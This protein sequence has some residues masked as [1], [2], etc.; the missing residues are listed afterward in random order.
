MAWYFKPNTTKYWESNQCTRLLGRL[1]SC[2]GMLAI[3]L[4][5]YISYSSR[6]EAKK[7]VSRLRFLLK[8]SSF[9]AGALKWVSSPIFRNTL[10]KGLPSFMFT[11][12]WT[13]YMYCTWKENTLNIRSKQDTQGSQEFFPNFSCRQI[14]NDCTCMHNLK[15]VCCRLPNDVPAKFQPAI[16][17]FSAG[18]FRW[19]QQLATTLCSLNEFPL[20]STLFWPY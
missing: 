13:Q 7:V 4:G 10:N 1:P 14:L 20:C 8:W 19:Q 18:K 2:K 3:F 12:W 16:T 6:V 17:S 9:F 11:R 15:S 5:C